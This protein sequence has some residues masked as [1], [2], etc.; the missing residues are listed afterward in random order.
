MSVASL[1]QVRPKDPLTGHV[2]VLVVGA[3]IS[4]I[5]LGHYLAK[6]RP[7]STFAIVDGR[8][9]IGGTWDLFRYPGIRSDSDLHTFGYEFKPWTSDNAIADAHEILSYLHEVIE[10]DG[11]GKRNY[12]HHKVVAADFSTETGR[13][14]VTLERDGRRWDITC[15]WLFGATGYYDYASGYTPYFEGQEDFKGQIVHPQFWPEDLDYS[16][17]EIVVIGSG[18]TAVTLIPAMAPKAKHITMLQRSPSYVM[19]LPRKDPL[20]NSLR[21]VLPEKAAYAATRRFNIG[22]GRF[23]YNLC[24]RNPKLARRIIRTLNVK[25]LPAG[26]DVDTHFNPTYNPWDQRLC[27]VPDADLFRVISKGKASVV[28]DGID[29]FT[30]NG[31]LLKSGRELPA[32]IIITAT[33]LKMKLFGGIAVSVDGEVKN[34]HDSLVYKSFMLSDI[35]NLAFA[36]G[37]TNSSWTL[38]VDLVCE[39]L[40]RLLAYMDQHGYTTVVPVADDPTLAKRPMLDFDAGYILRGRDQFPQQGT[41]GPWTV[42]MDYWADHARLRKGP[43]EDAA[44]RFS[45]ASRTPVTAVA[46]R[47]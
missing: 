39:H 41:S 33:G 18:A 44:L 46:A 32:D 40:C 36:F 42:E 27:A 2:D 34:P 4:G 8:D 30:T 24:Q 12:F 29:R 9:A 17:K 38:K 26:Y 15:N 20:A 23:I 35:P 7:G 47:A 21:K 22:K 25:S 37:Y 31:I 13:W 16:G 19:P 5:G 1:N 43:V 14:A 3:G 10:E 6:Q 45:T 11:L 28:T